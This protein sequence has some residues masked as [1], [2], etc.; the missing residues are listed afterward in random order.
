MLCKRWVRVGYDGVGGQKQEEFWSP[1]PLNKLHV[2]MQEVVCAQKQYKFIWIQQGKVGCVVTQLV[3][4]LKAKENV[5]VASIS[6]LLLRAEKIRNE[7]S[8]GKDKKPRTAAP[9]K[10]THINF[11]LF[12]HLPLTIRFK[13]FSCSC[14][15]IILYF[16]EDG[17]V[18]M[19]NNN[20]SQ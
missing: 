14:I 7:K 6:L 2:C 1:A 11:H 13:G 20:S 4:G 17:V 16:L 19:V 18:V 3:S 8:S 5:D 15:F 10:Y 12:H 9:H